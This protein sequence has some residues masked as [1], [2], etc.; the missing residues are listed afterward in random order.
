MSLSTACVRDMSY[1]WAIRSRPAAATKF[2]GVGTFHCGLQSV[3]NATCPWPYKVAMASNG[4]P[5]FF[6]AA[7]LSR[8]C[9]HKAFHA[10]RQLALRPNT[11]SSSSWE[12]CAWGAGAGSKTVRVLRLT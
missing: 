7:S 9:A 11:V 8:A 12:K 10:E 1:P 4:C 5:I 3:A 2:A 6:C